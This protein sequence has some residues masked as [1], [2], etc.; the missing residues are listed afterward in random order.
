MHSVEAGE[1][2]LLLDVWLC[3]K[4]VEELL[5]HLPQQRLRVVG[6]GQLFRSTT[7]VDSSGC[8]YHQKVRGVGRQRAMRCENTACVIHQRLALQ[9]A[10]IST[11]TWLSLLQKPYTSHLVVALPALHVHS[12]PRGQHAKGPWLHCPAQR[13]RSSLHS[14]VCTVH[15]G[16]QGLQ[17]RSCKPLTEAVDPHLA[18]GMV[19]IRRNW[20]EE[21]EA[22]VGSRNQRSRSQK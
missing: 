9:P 18:T 4:P 2:L 16:H 8:L 13:R 1:R 10:A 7:G 17:Q 11:Q 20:N 12:P 3:A 14:G 21:L 22:T 19:R 6:V 15:S 5:P